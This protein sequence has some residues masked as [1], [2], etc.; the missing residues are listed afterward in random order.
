MALATSEFPTH[1]ICGLPF[2]TALVYLVT[3]KAVVMQSV[4]VVLTME[5]LLL[6]IMHAICNTDRAASTSIFFYQKEIMEIVDDLKVPTKLVTF[7]SKL[8]WILIIYLKFIGLLQNMQDLLNWLRDIFRTI[9]NLLK[10]SV[11][12]SVAYYRYDGHSLVTVACKDFMHLTFSFHY[13]L[14]VRHV[15]DE[16]VFI[17]NVLWCKNCVMLD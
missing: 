11:H 6:S 13:S 16:F 12:D 17:H 9:C 14:I 7:V 5:M 4:E 3:E 15:F 8:K 2:E 10:I 1:I